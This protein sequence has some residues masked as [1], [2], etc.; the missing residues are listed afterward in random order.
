MRPTRRESWT[1][2]RPSSPSRGTRRERLSTPAVKGAPC[3]QSIKI[4]VVVLPRTSMFLELF[5]GKH[6]VKSRLIPI[7]NRVLTSLEHFTGVYKTSLDRSSLPKLHKV[8]SKRI[9]RSCCTRTSTYVCFGPAELFCVKH[10]VKFVLP[11]S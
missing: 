3:F 4:A 1:P 5:C 2:T 8:C 6:I 7:L 9:N 10:L 11:P